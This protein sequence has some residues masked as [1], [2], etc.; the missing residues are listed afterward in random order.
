MGMNI[1]IGIGVSKLGRGAVNSLLADLN[2]P[3]TSYWGDEGH[4]S[5]WY[6]SSQFNS[7]YDAVGNKT[8]VA[9]ETIFQAPVKR[10][11][12]VRVYDH[13]TNL[14]GQPVGVGAASA[15]A[16][17]DHGVPA[18]AMNADGRIV[19]SWGNHDG[20]FHLS[21]STNV[22]DITQWTN[23]GDLTG[24]YA[25]P[26]LVLM[27]D[28]S[29][30]V[31]LRKNFAPGTGG[32]AAGAK[33]FVYRPLTFVGATITIGA[34]VTIGDLGNDSRWY[35]G[36]AYLR[37]DNLVHQ[38]CTK[39]NFNDDWRRNAY[40]YKIDI[41][42]QRLVA[43]D[44]TL[45]AFPVA[46]A[47][48]EGASFKVFS[49]TSPNTSNTPGFAFDT[50]GRAHILIC[51]GDTSDGGV[52]AQ[53]TPQ[54]VKHLVTSGTVF[55]TPVI[56]GTSTHRYNGYTVVPNADGS[57]E[58]YWSKDPA[59]INIRGGSI[60]K[61][62]LL[63]NQPSTAFKNEQRVADKDAARGALDSPVTV[64]DAHA[65]LSVLWF[66]RPTDSLDASAVDQRKFGWGASGVKAKTR[67]SLILPPN[68]T[69]DGFWLDL[70][71]LTRVFSDLGVTQAVK[72][73]VVKQVNDRFGTNN[74][75]QSGSVG[76]F[77]DKLGDQWGLKF[78]GA[79][80]GTR[81]LTGPNKAWT[82]GGYM[83][84][85]ILR[86][87]EPS[88][89]S[90][91]PLSYEAG[92][93][94]VRLGKINVN[95]PQLRAQAFNGTV[96]TLI[97]TGASGAPYGTD[98]II[99][100]YTIGSTEYLYVNGVL[101]DSSAITGG[102]INTGSVIMRLGASAAGTPANFFMGMIFGCVFRSGEQTT[103]MRDNDLAWAQTQLPL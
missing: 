57:V 90:Q 40:Y 50:N 33:V 61:R 84:T 51:E 70:S 87:W 60:V 78:T 85:L 73:D 94:N 15:L 24:A 6:N 8:Y 99:Q 43:L 58:C 27:P 38:V 69:G 39:A 31:L 29:M 86:H 77:L 88:T 30:I 2:I 36:N 92:A 95:G 28:N 59:N 52:G 13:A 5:A 22:R 75:T 83:V 81:Y 80:A 34:E 7:F 56:I 14:W 76:P 20:N 32:F 65:D 35:Q 48:M 23:P 44:G 12:H 3:V 72:G 37:G 66:E 89:I 1:G 4:T 54:D 68:L 101:R 10:L 17:D 11:V 98:Y 26:H 46:A 42:N 97:G 53:A 96:S 41:P 21:I 74:F 16:N 25:Y 62:K 79:S 64:K 45:A 19:I 82:N 67:P 9:Y 71:D 47:T 49:T 63:A 55:Q 91:D 100:A 18:I 103:T 93:G 102:P